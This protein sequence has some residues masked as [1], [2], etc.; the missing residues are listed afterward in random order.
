MP[1]QIDY[2]CPGGKGRCIFICIH[3]TLYGTTPTCYWVLRMVEASSSDIKDN[4]NLDN[5]Q[6]INL[7]IF[8]ALPSL[9]HH[10]C[11]ASSLLG[12]REKKRKTVVCLFIRGQRSRKKKIEKI[13][14]KR[15]EKR[16]RA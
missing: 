12:P 16:K 1:L 9:V 3:F 15:G 11:C 13:A 5:L 4:K 7:G 2:L 10:I 6:L 8:P 14:K